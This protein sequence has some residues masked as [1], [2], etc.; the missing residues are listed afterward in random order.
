MSAKSWSEYDDRFGSKVAA[1]EV[2][3]DGASGVTIDERSERTMRDLVR[4]SWR[5]DAQKASAAAL[6]MSIDFVEIG[7]GAGWRVRDF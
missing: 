5:L 7:I 6:K 1:K 2:E 4:L 3:E